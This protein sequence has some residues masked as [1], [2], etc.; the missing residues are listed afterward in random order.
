[1][2]AMFVKFNFCHWVTVICTFNFSLAIL[3]TKLGI[4]K[5][6]LWVFFSNCFN[7]TII[8]LLKKTKEKNFFL[9][10]KNNF[11]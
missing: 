2:A 3:S 9:D 5:R 8:P 11:N 6:F 7:K 10:N 1:M 4:S